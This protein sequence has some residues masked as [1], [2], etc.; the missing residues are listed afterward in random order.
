ME[1]TSFKG[2]NCAKFDVKYDKN[3]GQRY[4]E[5]KDGKIQLPIGLIHQP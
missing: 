2:K 1:L 3:T 5:C 4:L